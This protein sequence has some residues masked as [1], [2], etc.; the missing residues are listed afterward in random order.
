LH[1]LSHKFVAQ[2]FGYFAEYRANRLGLILDSNRLVWTVVAVPTI[3][4][5]LPVYLGMV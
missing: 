2:R 5:A 1:E 3:L 4:A